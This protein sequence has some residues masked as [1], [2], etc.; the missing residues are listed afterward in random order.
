[1]SAQ[2]LR[3]GFIP[4]NDCAPLV[5]ARERGFFAAEGLDVELVR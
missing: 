1:M 2:T 5:V 3:L 4:L